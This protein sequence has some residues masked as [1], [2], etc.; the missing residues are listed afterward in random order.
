VSLANPILTNKGGTCRL[1]P[2]IA[3]ARLEATM[4]EIERVQTELRSEQ[5]WLKWMAGSVVAVMLAGTGIGL[6][7]SFVLSDRLADVQVDTAAIRVI[8]EK[9][10]TAI[11]S[12]VEKMRA[13]IQRV[14]DAVGAKLEEKKAEL[15]PR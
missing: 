7:R 12:D 10:V 9:D 5:T 13:D 3:F 1:I 8:V 14:A 2:T 15:P 11:R 4:R 6:S